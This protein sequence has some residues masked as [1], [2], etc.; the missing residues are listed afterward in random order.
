[1]KKAGVP[2]AISLAFICF[3]VRMTGYRQQT[4]VILITKMVAEKTK[5]V[6]ASSNRPSAFRILGYKRFE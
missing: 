3:K 5:W 1:M 2:F 4:A 6:C